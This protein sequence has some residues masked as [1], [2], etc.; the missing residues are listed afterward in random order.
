MPKRVQMTRNRPWRP[1]NPD[2]VVVD[3]RS[4][5]GNPYR[6]G[7]TGV[8]DARAA[9]RL[10]DDRIARHLGNREKIRRELAGKD[11]A[12]W[13]LLDA[14]CHADVLLQVAN[15]REDDRRLPIDALPQKEP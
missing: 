9:V 15:G 14:P 1:D 8:P 6:V 12:C 5:W 11:L 4:R 10:F 7:D 13:C 2:A 3:R